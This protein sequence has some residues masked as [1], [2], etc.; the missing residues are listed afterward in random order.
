MNT[1]PPRHV[2]KLF[3]ALFFF[4][5]AALPAAADDDDDEIRGYS[6]KQ[7]LITSVQTDLATNEIAIVGQRLAGRNNRDLNDGR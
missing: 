5:C 1:Q 4:Q 7:L 6:S 2:F 3:L